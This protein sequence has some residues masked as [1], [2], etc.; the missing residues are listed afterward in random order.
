MRSL[1]TN[2]GRN[3]GTKFCQ[4]NCHPCS[5]FKTKGLLGGI[6]IGVPI[7]DNMHQ[8]DIRFRKQ[9][10]ES[11]KARHI[12][13]GSFAVLAITYLDSRKPRAQHRVLPGSRGQLTICTAAACLAAL[14]SA[15][16]VMFATVEPL[17][18]GGG[19]G[20]TLSLSMQSLAPQQKS[21][22]TTAKADCD[23]DECDPNH[24]G[25]AVI[26]ASLPE[27]ATDVSQTVQRLAMDAVWSTQLHIDP[28]NDLRTQTWDE[29]VRAKMGHCIST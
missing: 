2:W 19:R 17:D 12:I 22:D 20:H 11:F 6:Y 13:A 5:R 9:T 29:K 27:A 1:G 15:Q 24:C 3:L 14:F 4:L 8:W 7:I 28:Q 23:D 16:S 25:V 10:K 26:S 21:S 18:V